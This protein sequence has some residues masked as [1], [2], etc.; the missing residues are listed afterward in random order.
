MHIFVFLS[1]GQT[2]QT[3]KIQSMQLVKLLMPHINFGGFICFEQILKILSCI[4][5]TEIM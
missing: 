5:Y 2:N 1:R 4:T 3:S